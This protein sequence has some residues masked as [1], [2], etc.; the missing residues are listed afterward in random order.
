MA[1]VGQ[2]LAWPLL[3][4]LAAMLLSACGSPSSE[5]AERA[6]ELLARMTLEEKIGQMTLI[7][8]TAVVGC[9]EAE[10][11]AACDLE[12]IAEFGVGAL[13]SGG[14]SGPSQNDVAGWR[15]MV[16]EFQDAA[17][18]SR[19]GIPLLYGV[20]A[21]HGHNNVKGTVIFPHNIGLGAAGDA[22]LVERIGR[23]TAVEVAATGIRW[24]YAPVL[25]VV[26]DVRWGR[27]YESFGEDPDLVSD[28]GA[29]LVRGLQAGDTTDD[30]YVLATPKH[31]VGDGGTTWG[32]GGR[33][34]PIDQGV[35]EI[36]EDELR[37]VHLSPYPA[38]L[39]AGARTVMATYSS[40]DNG[41]V[42]GD[43]YLLTD[44]LRGELD[45]AG[46]V[47]S[48][49]AGVDQVVPGDLEASVAQSVNA[50]IDLVMVPHDLVGFQ[51]ALRDVVLQGLVP[52]ERIDEA[53]LRILT[54]KYEIGLFDRPLPGVGLAEQVGGD[55]HRALGAEAAAKSVVLLETG[56]GLLPLPKS[57]RLL[58][59]GRAADD[60]GIQS[61]GWTIG[62]QG[63]P[64][65][66]TD[67]T[68]IVEALEAEL[69]DGVE[70]EP[71]GSFE[72]PAKTGL[73][74]LGEG[75]YAEG[76]GDSATLPLPNNELQV[77]ERMREHV[78]RLVV[79]LL[80]GRPVVLDAVADLADV[81]VV[82]WLPGTEGQGVVDV[83]TGARDVTGVLPVTWP[84]SPDVA[85]RFEKEACE[86]A[87]YPVGYG[88]GFD[89]VPLE[90]VGPCGSP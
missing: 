36:S 31:F 52:E 10:W 75:P 47:V 85:P 54:V 64:G 46:L 33:G 84:A 11:V 90:E 78:D 20:D 12:K 61:G 63:R 69:G 16:E 79:V 56:P 17:L 35:T 57:E 70:Y 68:T 62:W 1:L 7:E 2:R 72:T 14:G 38:S 83:L 48:D 71:S 80:V 42:H 82:A 34:Y 53:V 89:G 25:A 3:V 39:A 51:T 41:K 87:L 67:G 40:W 9:D 55:E 29:A 32:T 88:L 37:A 81:I 19:L 27:T 60:I 26:Q 49:W 86:D 44:V 65:D 13:L 24:T 59:G 22:D 30:T 18:S 8:R 76:L 50:G 21:V 4:V 23:A 5:A 45:F 6:E 43:R 15:S 58:V 77:L 66:I 73:V 28:L 74:V